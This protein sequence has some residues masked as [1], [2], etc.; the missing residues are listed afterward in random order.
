MVSHKP[1]CSI[2]KKSVSSNKLI[3]CELCLQI[4]HYR[5]NFL[6]SV[7]F[8]TIKQNISDW[9]C[10]N[11]SKNI[12]PFVELNDYRFNAVANNNNLQYLADSDSLSLKPPSNLSSLYNHFNDFTSDN[13]SSNDIINCKYY[14]VEE[15]S[16]LKDF[17]NNA[18][19]SLFHL[20]ISSLPK[21]IDEL[22][23]LIYSSGLNFDV[24]AISESRVLRNTNTISNINFAGYS[25]ESCPTVSSTGGTGIYVKNSL[26]YTPRP[27]LQIYKPFELESNFVEIINPKRSNI[28]VG[29][30]YRHPCMGLNEFNDDY[31][32]VLLEKLS[33]ENKTIF[34]LGDFNVDLLK[35]DKNNSTNDFLDSISSNSFLPQILLPTRIVGTSKTLIDNIFS[36][37]ISNDILSGNITASI[38]DHLPQICIVPN[39]FSNSPTPKI[40]V[41]ER[42][43]KNFNQE[44]FLIDFAA[45]DWNLMLKI[46]QN[47]VN[48]SF[49]V[50]LKHIN[51][52][53]DKF[54]PFKKISKY[55]LKFKSKPWISNSIQKSICTKNKYFTKYIRQKDPILKSFWHDKYKTYRNA[56]STLLKQSK[57]NYYTKFFNSNINNIKNTWKGI[58]S[59]IS[60]GDNESFAP[61]S[62]SI[63]KSILT[64]P[65]IIANEF[66]NYFCSIGKKIQSNIK[67]SFRDFHF[68]LGDLFEKS[69]FVS[70]TDNMEIADIISNLNQYKSEGPNGIPMKILHLLRNDISSILADLFNLSFSSGVFPSILKIAKVIPVH[71]K[72]SKLDTSNYRPI[73]ILSNLD[74]IIER[75]MYNRLYKFLESNDLIYSLQF[76]F[77]KNY[78]TSLA[79]LSLTENIKQEIDKGRFGCGIFIDFQKAFDTV[80]HNILLEKLHHYGIRGISNNWF[81]SY[82]NDRKQY[83]TINGYNSDF[84]SIECGI[85]QGSILGPLLF[86]IYINDLHS[87]IKFCKTHHFADDTNLLYFDDS[88]KKLEKFI[89]QDL[90][91]LMNWLN[92]NKI[93]LNA[94]KT[95][96]VIF[97]PLRKVLD[98]NLNLRL[99]RKRLYPTSSVKY[100]GVKIDSK[101]NWKDHC[102]SVSIKLSRGNAILSKLRHF[103]DFSTLKSIYHSFFES[104]FNYA[105]IV[106]AQNVNCTHRLFLLQKKALRIINFADRFSHTNPLFKASDIIKF[107]D[108][109]SIDNCIFIS[110]ALLN[111]L[112]P[113]FDDWFVFSSSGHSH[114]LRSTDLGILKI[115]TFHTKSHGRQSFKVNAIYT[116]NC[117]Q[118]Q[119]KHCKLYELKPS[120]IKTVLVMY[121]NKSYC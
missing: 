83:V 62:I 79:L 82:L 39:I 60:K 73:S 103:V 56:L 14:N 111:L 117:I 65:N 8:Q 107:H 99:N 93:S 104:N 23:H 12:F 3:T 81:K 54:A 59:I 121:F 50:F 37:H 16:V 2:C 95:E 10:I 109:V 87:S 80:D 30:V 92:A 106:W 63:N 11:C 43:W 88:F 42:D 91:N 49:N 78:S 110:K 40:N 22:E 66:N 53:L 68:F 47:D 101:L 27:D 51:I 119:L 64:E 105:N 9:Q 32:N 24:L 28:I 102:N 120:K 1:S 96:L 75:L 70:P 77:R 36:N 72:S 97:K 98:Y 94:D 112:P 113:I 90:K 33:K 17:Q 31:L 34:I 76:G 58:K 38:S 114:H 57:K 44:E 85:P 29:C 35:Y 19:L 74:K 46:G 41:Y 86:L 5:C 48:S 6:N 7:D 13:K 67:H 115:P 26:S 52:L 108:K 20:N 118:N 21:H 71:K 55:K 4:S 84:A 69:F 18:S 116:W 89:N 61:T 100:L 45:S 15:L 25:F